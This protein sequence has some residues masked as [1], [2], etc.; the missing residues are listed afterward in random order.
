MKLLTFRLANPYLGIGAGN[1]ILLRVSNPN[2]EEQI[3]TAI[4]RR[5]LPIHRALVDG[6][7]KRLDTVWVSL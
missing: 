5:L 7:N 6:V 3:Q 4:E 2:V 1:I